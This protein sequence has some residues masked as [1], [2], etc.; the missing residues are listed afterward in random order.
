MKREH[1]MIAASSRVRN[2][3]PLLLDRVREVKAATPLSNQRAVRSFD[4]IAP[5]HC[6][7]PEHAIVVGVICSDIYTVLTRCGEH[8]RL[9]QFGLE[10]TEPVCGALYV[11]L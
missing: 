7:G 4:N 5:G 1:H 9:I 8:Y 10:I 11:S 2:T 6:A 3:E